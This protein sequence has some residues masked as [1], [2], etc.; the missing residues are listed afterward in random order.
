MQR[1]HYAGDTVLIPDIVSEAVLR[2]ARSLAQVG[3][4][5]VVRVPIVDEAGAVSE[6]ELLIGPASE[7][8]TTPAPD[9]SEIEVDPGVVE[10]I[11]RRAESLAEAQRRAEREATSSKTP[12]PDTL[13]E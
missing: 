11:N 9:V 3:I 1:L 2:F 6:A 7:L 8:Y 13:A 10:E 12:L 5:D 4:S